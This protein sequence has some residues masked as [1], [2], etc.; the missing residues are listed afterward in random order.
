MLHHLKGA[1]SK[2]E[3]LVKGSAIAVIFMTQSYFQ[4]LAALLYNHGYLL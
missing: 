3:E 1:I 4:C 2:L